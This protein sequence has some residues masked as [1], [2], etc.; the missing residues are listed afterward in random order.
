MMADTNPHDKNN[1]P[2]SISENPK[3]RSVKGVTDVSSTAQYKAILKFWPRKVK[4][5]NVRA[6]QT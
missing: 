6:P 5:A 1:I 3:N 4:I 2:F